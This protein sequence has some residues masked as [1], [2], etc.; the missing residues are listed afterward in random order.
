MQDDLNFF[1][2]EEVFDGLS[3]LE[4]SDSLVL[5]CGA[6]VTFDLTG[7]GWSNLVKEILNS[8]LQN[9]PSNL[10]KSVQYLI[11]SGSLEDKQ[12]ASL[13]TAFMEDDGIPFSSTEFIEI[14]QDT[15]YKKHGWER[16]KLLEDIVGLAISLAIKGKTVEIITTNYDVYI[17]D[18]FKEGIK[19]RT[20]LGVETLPEIFLKDFK[21]GDRE[22]IISAPT[23]IG[24]VDIVYLHGRIDR[25]GECL[26]LA[27][28]DIVFSELSYAETREQ[29]TGYLI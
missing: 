21:T 6:G 15:L 27:D 1:S 4:K 3:A 28:R 16:G 18:A 19:G 22:S 7:L 25:P 24:E 26:P 23:K 12:K 17:I 11:S 8:A 9:P 29:T 10:A 13:V 14:L 20:S 5:Y 2:K